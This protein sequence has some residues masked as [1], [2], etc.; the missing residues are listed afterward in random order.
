M[1]PRAVDPGT[2]PARPGDAEP[3]TIDFEGRRLTGL[4]GQSVA[5][6]LLAN[7]IESWRSTADAR[8]PRGLFCGI[9]VC[10]DCVVVVNGHR[11]VRACQHLATDGDRVE[12]QDD[13][14][15]TPR[16]GSWTSS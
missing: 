5:G 9:G 3:V 13:R 1:S 6:V 11:D 8:Q 16:S 14:L 7:G 12:R 15:P 10:F 2:D 4:R